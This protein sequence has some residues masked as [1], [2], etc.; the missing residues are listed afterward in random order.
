MK[1]AESHWHFKY[2][3]MYNRVIDL[4]RTEDEARREAEGL[5]KRLAEVDPVTLRRHVSDTQGDDG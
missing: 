4:R 3:L 5:L 2:V 1:P